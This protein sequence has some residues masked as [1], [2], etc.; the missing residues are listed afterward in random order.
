MKNSMLKLFHFKKS[1]TGVVLFSFVLFTG[2]TFTPLNFD[3]PLPGADVGREPVWEPKG[4]FPVQGN[5]TI[6]DRDSVLQRVEEMIVT[7]RAISVS[8]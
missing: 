7:E 6:R 1:L 5:A 2:A 4:A 8:V 3:L